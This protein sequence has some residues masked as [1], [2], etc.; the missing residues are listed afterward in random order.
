LIDD[1]IRLYYIYLLQTKDKTLDYFKIYRPALETEMRG[2]L[3]Y[4]AT[5]RTGVPCVGTTGA[6]DTT[7]FIDLL[8]EG[9][10]E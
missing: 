10:D 7:P 3:E 6:M 9:E 5:W 8:K 4:H 1:A 2:V